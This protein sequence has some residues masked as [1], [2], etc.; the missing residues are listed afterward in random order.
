MGPR[1]HTGMKT[2]LEKPPFSRTAFVLL[3]HLRPTQ[4][5]RATKKARAKRYKLLA[6]VAEIDNQIHAILTQLRNQQ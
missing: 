6:Q 2:F 3:P 5:S 1:Y 4:D